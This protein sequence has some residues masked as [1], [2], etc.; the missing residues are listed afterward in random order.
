LLLLSG[1]VTATSNVYGNKCDKRNERRIKDLVNIL[2]FR[3]CYHRAPV[4]HR[5]V[6]LNGF[7]EN[8]RVSILATMCSCCEDG[9]LPF[10]Q[11]ISVSS[12]SSCVTA[13]APSQFVLF[14]AA[15]TPGFL[16]SVQLIDFGKIYISTCIWHSYVKI[17]RRKG[18]RILTPN[19]LLSLEVM[20]NCNKNCINIVGKTSRYILISLEGKYFSSLLITSCSFSIPFWMMKRLKL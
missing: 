3:C 19:R 14:Y 13:H 11:R 20:L 10:L 17:Q 12:H 18:T 15:W 8:A 16:A 5:G 4:L 6:Q 2:F 1:L 9:N 7:V